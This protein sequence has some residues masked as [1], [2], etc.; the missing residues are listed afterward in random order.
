MHTYCTFDENEWSRKWNVQNVLWVLRTNQKLSNQ[1]V[2]LNSNN[3]L[4]PPLQP[5]LAWAL[6]AEEFGA[7]MH[8]LQFF[9]FFP[10]IEFLE[11]SAKLRRQK[12]KRIFLFKQKEWFILPFKN[13][14]MIIVYDTPPHPLDDKN[15]WKSHLMT[16]CD[17]VTRT[18]HKRKWRCSS[19]S[20]SVLLSSVY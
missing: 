13:Y 15:Y 9:P 2:W 17:P 4:S 11:R 14:F 8:Y 12:D 10:C 20:S 16:R 19:Q 3:L 5:T 18:K 7:E 1:T 6:V